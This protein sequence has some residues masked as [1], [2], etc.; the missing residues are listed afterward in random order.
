MSLTRRVFLKLSAA[1][2]AALA[3]FP[4]AALAAKKKM[5]VP[6]AKVE[7]LKAVDG[8]AVL[9]IKD[10]KVLF[11]RESETKVNAVSA[12]CTHQKCQVAYNP[13]TKRIECACHGSKFTP[14]G[15]VLNGPATVSLPNY[16]AALDGERIII[17]MEE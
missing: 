3:L 13:A 14:A 8:W 16:N 11:I 10:K 4:R 7:K 5:A 17:E 6:L 1:A 9:Q 15:Q 12:E 2:T